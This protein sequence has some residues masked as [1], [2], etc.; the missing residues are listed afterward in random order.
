MWNCKQKAKSLFIE[1]RK[2]NSQKLSVEKLEKFQ[3][4]NKK[5]IIHEI[6]HDTWN[7]SIA[8]QNEPSQVSGIKK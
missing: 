8:H 6:F 5:K 2:E 4:N 7:L 1:R 3:S